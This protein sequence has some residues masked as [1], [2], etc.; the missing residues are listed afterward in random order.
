VR[1]WDVDH[2]GEGD[3][4][5]AADCSFGGTIVTVD[6]EAEIFN[7]RVDDPRFSG[8][9]KDSVLAFLYR[10]VELVLEPDE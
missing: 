2:V 8:I 3:S 9:E 5:E 1:S 6:R 10:D 7:V 4:V